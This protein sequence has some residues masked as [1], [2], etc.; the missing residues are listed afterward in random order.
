MVATAKDKIARLEAE[1][2]SLRDR[3]MLRSALPLSPAVASE[4]DS[5][6]ESRVLSLLREC[7]DIDALRAAVGDDE[8]ALLGGAGDGGPAMAAMAAHQRLL[9]PLLPPS[10]ENMHQL[11]ALAPSLLPLRPSATPFAH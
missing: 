9:D 3:E 2:A 1:L 11:Q 8:P 6:L 5:E 10:S 4:L 7:A